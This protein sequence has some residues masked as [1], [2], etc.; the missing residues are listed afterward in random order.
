[1]KFLTSSIGENY[2]DQNGFRHACPIDN[3]NGF[4]DK[5][6]QVLPK[7]PKVLFI[8]ADPAAH[9]INHYMASVMIDAFFMSDLPL[10]QLIYCD[11]RNGERVKQLIDEADCVILS[12]GHVPTQN[13]FFSEIGLKEALADYPGTLISISA[14]TMNCAETVYASPEYPEEERDPNYQFFYEG[15]GFTKVN[16]LPHFQYLRE[17]GKIAIPLEFSKKIP[18]YGL[19][20]GAYIQIEEDGSQAIFGEA[21]LLQDGKIIPI[22]KNDEK[23]QL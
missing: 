20:D 15:L 5:L 18:I 9:R 7:R 1:M 11:D 2:E 6:K 19:T 23:Y 4:L 14:G 10:G 16:V 13:A 21:Y 22:C 8:A 12:G 17:I 3:R